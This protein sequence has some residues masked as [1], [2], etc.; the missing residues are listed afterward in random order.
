MQPVGNTPSLVGARL[1]DRANRDVAGSIE[2]IASGKR[3]NRA[4]DDPSG[5]I[6]AENLAAILAA[7]DAETRSLERTHQ[8]ATTA[9]GALDAVGDLLVEAEA[10]AVANANTAG[11]SAE[12]QAANQMELD[13][14]LGTINRLASTTHF[15]GSPLLDG[16]ASIGVDGQSVTIGSMS[17]GSIGA[18]TIDGSTYKLA[19]VGSGGGLANDPGGALAAIQAARAEVNE[20]RGRIGA[21]Q[22]N[23]IRPRLDSV[24]VTIENVAAATSAIRDTDYAVETSRFVRS[25]MLAHSSLTMMRLANSAPS[26]VEKLL[27]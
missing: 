10:L 22:A 25:Q 16:S 26:F 27:G 17:T 23:G 12:E 18:V 21:L 13:S 19:D 1:L 8:T 4:A 5:L 14:L 15:N 9:D 3:I 24:G 11:L 7:L 20:T 2:R 6:T